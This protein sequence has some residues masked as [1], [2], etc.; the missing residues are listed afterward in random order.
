M[1]EGYSE[2]EYKGLMKKRNEAPREGVQEFVVQEVL[3][4]DIAKG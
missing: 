1:I 3:Y 2:L 4:E